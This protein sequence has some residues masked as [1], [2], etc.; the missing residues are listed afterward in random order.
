MTQVSIFR[1]HL[2]AIANTIQA[3]K[4]QW[5]LAEWI[6]NFIQ[7]DRPY[8]G[9][10]DYDDNYLPENDPMPGGDA[11]GMYD[12][13]SEDGLFETALILIL[14]GALILLL[15]YRQQHQLAHRRNEEAAGGQ[16]NGQQPH[17]QQP[18]Q[19]QGLF[20]GPGDPDFN[21][22]VAGGIGH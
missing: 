13:V 1:R 14:A 19:D 6:N 11:D 15:W 21:Q 9:D 3:P 20:P 12:D 5:S 22:W 10:A 2:R 7:D 4:K 17:G 18:Q 8:Y 16:Q